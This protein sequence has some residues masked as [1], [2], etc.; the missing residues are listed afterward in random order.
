MTKKFHL[1]WF[2]NFVPPE[3]NTTWA[4]PDVAKWLRQA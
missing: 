1:G 4:S 3:W 2:M